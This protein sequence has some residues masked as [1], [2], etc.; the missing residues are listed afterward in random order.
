MNY[1]FNLTS[2][3][4]DKLWGYNHEIGISVDN[5]FKNNFTLGLTAGFIFGNQLKDSTI[6]S[7]VFNE[8]G[9]ITNLGGG[10]AQVLFL[11]RGMT[12]QLNAGYLFNRLGN[13]PNSGLWL[14]A[15]AGFLM[16]KIRIESLY[17]DVPQL[18]GDYRKGYD[19][20]HMGFAFREFVGYLFQ[21]DRRFL[22]FYAGFEFIQG[23][24]QNQRNYNFDLGG[25]D[26]GIKQDFL[27]SAKVGWLIPIYKRSA[28][29]YYVD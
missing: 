15:G 10:P 6:F 16:H 7:S 14:Q 26:P 21:A 27:W 13:N 20:L 3:D 23:F 12:A 18:E 11:M 17:D 2:G 25:P 8:F 19:R 29:E 4:L 22:N 1:K 28:K 5:K 9:T 24:T